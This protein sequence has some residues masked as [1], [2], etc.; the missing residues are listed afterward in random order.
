MQLIIKGLKVV[1]FSSITE[2]DEI[3][4]KFFPEMTI[5]K[6]ID[7]DGNSGFILHKMRGELNSYFD[8]DSSFVS[9]KEIH[10]SL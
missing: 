7:T 10:I 1:P 4:K 6:A 2:A 8:K 3:V 5:V 9:R